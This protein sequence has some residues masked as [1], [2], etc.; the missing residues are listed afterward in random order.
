MLLA[1]AGFNSLLGV[2]ETLISALQ[3]SYDCENPKESESPRFQAILRVTSAPR[4][5]YPAD[6]KSFSHELNSKG[7]RPFPLWKR[8]GL[9]NLEVHISFLYYYMRHNGRWR[10]W[11]TGQMRI[12]LVHAK[13]NGT[14]LSTKTIFL[15]KQYF[16]YKYF[17]SNSFLRIIL[18][19]EFV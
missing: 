14:D 17:V 9:N 15:S 1:L 19:R 2:T 5:R 4:K 7:V 16:F 13:A 11:V 8:R 6:I 18:F 12:C 10:V 3:T